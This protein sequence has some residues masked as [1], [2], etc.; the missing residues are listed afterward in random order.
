[1]S[2]PKEAA[3]DEH[4]A[5]LVTRVIELCE[6]HKINAALQFLLDPGEEGPQCCTT[7]VPADPADDLGIGQLEALRR[8]MLRSPQ[9][10]AFTILNK[11]GS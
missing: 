10:T 8:V 3:Y 7:I 9:F 11:A 6:E 1:M 5:P 4:I 2:G